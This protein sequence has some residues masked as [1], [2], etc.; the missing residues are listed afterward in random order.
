[1]TAL[2]KFSSTPPS[3]CVT[4][5]G[6]DQEVAIGGRAERRA[7]AVGVLVQDVVADADVDGD[8][9]AEPEGRRPGR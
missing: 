6:E 2:P 7:V 3:S 9:D 4:A 1:M 5:C 8:R